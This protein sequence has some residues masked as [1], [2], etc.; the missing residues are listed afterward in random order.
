MSI[1][2]RRGGSGP[3][4]RV[5]FRGALHPAAG[6][7]NA[8]LTI[9]PQEACHFTEMELPARLTSPLEQVLRLNLPAQLPG[10][11]YH[12][13]A[14]ERPVERGEQRIYAV[15]SW[16]D[17]GDGV[18]IP[19]GRMV[20]LA[21]AENGWRYLVQPRGERANL[22]LLRDDGRFHAYTFVREAFARRLHQALRA[23]G[24]AAGDG[25]QVVEP[26]E[27]PIELPAGGGEPRCLHLD[28]PLATAQWQRLTLPQRLA[29]A[30]GL[31]AAA[32][33]RFSGPLLLAVAALIGL[34][35][36]GVAGDWRQARQVDGLRA[37]LDRLQRQSASLRETL[38]GMERRRQ[39]WNAL[40]L[41]LERNPPL[42]ELLAAVAP[43]L[44][45][46]GRVHTVEFTADGAAVTGLAR[47][48]TRALHAVEGL[49]A[50]R[51]A[52]FGNDLSRDPTRG[53]E[54]F[55]IE[56]R[57]PRPAAA[58]GASIESTAEAR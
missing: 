49:T 48:A 32:T 52:R 31:T 47:E 33:G 38:A 50:L 6:G 56:A 13:L 5:R 25:V 42:T 35:L 46:D 34:W 3:L 8:A 45:E 58:G 40:R 51:D 57:W 1:A 24:L 10:E 19:E 12:G 55:R 23:A 29:A 18:A 16:S 39:E 37:E 14:W 17:P 2:P 41:E 15:W 44:G 53:L 21:L 54:H 4:A 9:V 26:G 20:R 11:H 30:P 27:S 28:A 43:L 7:A 22:Y 36:G